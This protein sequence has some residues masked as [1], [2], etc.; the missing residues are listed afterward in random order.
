[1]VLNPG[2]PFK[3]VREL[4]KVH[5]ALAK[6]INDPATRKLIEAQGAEP[7]IGT[8]AE[9]LKVINEDYKRFAQAIKLAGLKVE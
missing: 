6:T 7:V 3:N 1:M 9:F 5:A 2:L 4:I 8:G